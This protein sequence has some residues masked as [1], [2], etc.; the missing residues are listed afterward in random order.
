MKYMDNN[1]NQN[2][3]GNIKMASRTSA[4][5]ILE[6]RFSLSARLPSPAGGLPI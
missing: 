2:N 1:L 5:N 6:N 4:E 3:A